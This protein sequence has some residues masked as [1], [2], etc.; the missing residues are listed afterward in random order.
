M[1]LSRI[2]ERDL[3][4]ALHEGPH[5]DPRWGTFLHRLQRRTRADYVAI[6]VGRRDVPIERKIQWFAGQDVQARAQT[7]D[8][9]AALDPTPYHLLRPGRVYSAFELIDPQDAV[10]SRFRRDY[11]ERIGI[12][13]GRFMRIPPVGELDG[14]L[15][16]T[17]AAD[18]FSAADGAL[19][20]SLAVHLQIALRTLV[21]IERSRFRD[22]ANDD[23]L[24]RAGVGW[25]ALDCSGRI[26]ERGGDTSGPAVPHADD[27]ADVALSVRAADHPLAATA[28]PA[29][30]VLTRRARVLGDR[31]ATALRDRFGLTQGEARIAVLLARGES[32]ADAART[33][34]LTLETA[35]NYSKRIFAK[36]GTRGQA[37][38]IRHILT[39]AD[40]L[41]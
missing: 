37:A 21:A 2:D 39:E 41:A 22:A 8:D 10:H 23:A 13:Y 33:L 18:D 4:P 34:G 27:P 1:T 40:G 26:V 24:C 15:I 14:W 7:L 28:L 12:R 31:V 5:E 6:V 29:T 19:I 9:L 11:L 35:R 30:V 32:L 36:T 17:R 38:L 3:L 16:V 20:S 25:A